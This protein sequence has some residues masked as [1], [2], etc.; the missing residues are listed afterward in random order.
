MRSV[1]DQNFFISVLHV[2]V[3]VDDWFDI[4]PS[5]DPAYCSFVEKSVQC[6][7]VDSFLGIQHG[8]QDHKDAIRCPNS[9][10]L[11]S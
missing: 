6:L 10:A 9:S 8:E 4:E 11:G 1:H 3:V 5:K 2:D 7:A